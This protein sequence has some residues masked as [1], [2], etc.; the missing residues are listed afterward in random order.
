M[1]KGFSSY[2]GTNADGFAIGNEKVEIKN[3]NNVLYH[4]LPNGTYTRTI[5]EAEFNSLSRA[6]RQWSSNTLFLEDE[7]IIYNG[8]LYLCN[9]EHTS[10]GVFESDVDNFTFIS[11]FDSFLLI[12]P[13]PLGSSI[14]DKTSGTLIY[15]DSAPGSGNYS[16]NLPD[17]TTLQFGHRFKIINASTAYTIDVYYHDGVTNLISIPPGTTVEV[18]YIKPNLSNGIFAT[19]DTPQSGVLTIS[20]VAHGFVFGDLLYIEDSTG[21]WKKAIASDPNKTCD[22]IVSAVYSVNSFQVTTSG[23]VNGVFSPSVTIG[24][25]YFLSD[26]AAGAYVDVEPLYI[27]QPVFKAINT[28]QILFRSDRPSENIASG[29]EFVLNVGQS[30][31]LGS[32]S[33]QYIIYLRSDPRVLA[34]T[35]YLSGSPPEFAPWTSPKPIANTDTPATLSIFDASGSLYVKNNLVTTENILV[36]K[37]YVSP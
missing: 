8:I 37:N 36:F 20:Q 28:N 27:S 14:L 7:L 10:G 4:R 1:N 32:D 3:I 23:Y 22:A 33:A 17:A 30:I 16:L 34:D 5:G 2:R 18:F 9:N 35:R 21:I 13:S 6:L 15:I 24:K 26:A 19:S 31:T 29:I 25:Q 12:A 11:V